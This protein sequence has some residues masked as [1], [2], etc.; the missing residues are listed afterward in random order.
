MAINNGD[1]GS[2]P[3]WF[4]N[5][6]AVICFGLVGAACMLILDSRHVTATELNTSQLAIMTELSKISNKMDGNLNQMRIDRIRDRISEIN[7]QLEELQV[8]MEE[9]PA[10]T[11]SKAWKQSVRRLANSKEEYQATLSILLKNGPT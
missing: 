2:L 9:A 1:K 8:Y 5:N 3:L 7:S 6:L 11:L 4:S 10:S